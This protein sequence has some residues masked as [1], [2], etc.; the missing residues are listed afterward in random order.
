MTG[1]SLIP[2]NMQ[3]ALKMAEMIADSELA[4][5]DYRNK[6]GN[7]LIA[8]QMGA[9]IGLSPMAAIQN[10]SV[11]NGR[12]A[13]WGDAG[14]ALLLSAGCIIEEDDIE[15]IRKTGTA[16]CKITRPNRPPVERTFG[17]EDAKTAGLLGKQ[18]PWREYRER[19]MAW[20][21]F[22]FCARDAAADILKGLGGKEEL[23]DMPEIDVTPAQ[24]KVDRVKGIL[25]GDAP[26]ALPATKAFDDIMTD[27]AK[28][29]TADDMTRIKEVIMTFHGDDKENAGTAWGER[30]KVLKKAAQQGPT[31]ADALAAVKNDQ[32]DIA[33]D[34]VKGKAFT[35]L[36][37]DT[38]EKAI[39]ARFEA[40]DLPQEPAGQAQESPQAPAK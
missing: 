7:V 20:R 14:K 26:L 35:D 40:T 4:P 29:T 37:R 6:P 8:V 34:M 28:S 5:K 30:L 18:G 2:A 16:R 38:V 3:E 39:E 31:I 27:I 17:I 10:I 9:E 24:A 33:R 19:Q 12:P 11:I 13:L 21:A 15:I 22:W 1:F 32:I 36:D 25:N 23:I